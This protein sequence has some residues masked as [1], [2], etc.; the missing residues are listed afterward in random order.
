[1]SYLLKYVYSQIKSLKNLP[2]VNC[3]S[4]HNRRLLAGETQRR[5]RRILTKRNSHFPLTT[6]QYVF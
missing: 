4:T 3:C 6:E 1:M 5:C 2:S